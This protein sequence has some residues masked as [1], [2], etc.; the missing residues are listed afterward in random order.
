MTFVVANDVAFEQ[1]IDVAE[2]IE[3]VVLYAVIVVQPKNEI[4]FILWKRLEIRQI[5]C[6]YCSLTLNEI[7]LSQRALISNI[8]W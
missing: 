4:R 8:F 6:A 7:I 2:R 5:F 3:V 1:D